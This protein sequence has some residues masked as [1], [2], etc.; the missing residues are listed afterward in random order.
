MTTHN[1]SCQDSR[2]SNVVL[3]GECGAFV[4]GGS[5]MW[6]KDGEQGAGPAPNLSG[7]PGRVGMGFTLL[8]GWVKSVMGMRLERERERE[9]DRGV[10]DA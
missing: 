6:G 4:S 10:M 7:L 5:S 3:D 9:D 2:W 8:G 1:P